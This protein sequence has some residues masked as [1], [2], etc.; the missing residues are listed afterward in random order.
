MK[1][2]IAP[3]RSDIVRALICD[4]ATWL[5]AIVA[6]LLAIPHG[7]VKGTPTA[8]LCWHIGV[9]GMIWT[10]VLLALGISVRST[11]I[12][13]L[14]IAIAFLLLR[15]AGPEISGFS[16][17]YATPSG[18]IPTLIAITVIAIIEALTVQKRT[19]TIAKTRRKWTHK[20]SVADLRRVAIHEVGHLLAYKLLP[21]RPQRMRAFVRPVITPDEPEGGAVTL[22]PMQVPGNR[23]YVVMLI[24]IAGLEAEFALLGSRGSGG[25]DDHAEW[26]ELAT[27]YAIEGHAGAFYRNP[28]TYWQRQVNRD[29]INSL[30][31]Q[32]RSDLNALFEANKDLL[33]E[34]AD[35]LLARHELGHNDVV[36]YLDRVDVR[37]LAYRIPS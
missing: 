22:L 25:G 24:K 16:V 35:D 26:M 4:P 7:S 14:C 37:P 12:R 33:G 5:A 32:Q 17:S 6:V 13:A 15:L 23:T 27:K 19:S 34:M 30:H 28:I 3:T 1:T 31:Q 20:Q 18:I 10:G 8:D 2:I 21:E 36:A 9:L 29:T 11:V